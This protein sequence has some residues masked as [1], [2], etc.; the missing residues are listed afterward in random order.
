[1]E[2]DQK[3][4]NRKTNVEKKGDEMRVFIC[5]KMD[6]GDTF[7]FI[8]DIFVCVLFRPFVCVCLICSGYSVATANIVSSL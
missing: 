5:D 2:R 4:Q 1:M 7:Q 3:I 8:C 6:E